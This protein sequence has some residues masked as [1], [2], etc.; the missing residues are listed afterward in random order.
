[1]GSPVYCEGASRSRSVSIPVSW[2]CLLPS[3]AIARPRLR[4]MELHSGSRFPLVITRS[5]NQP[6]GKLNLSRLVSLPIVQQQFSEVRRS[7]NDHRIA[8]PQRMIQYVE[9]FGSKFQ[10]DPFA[11]E[12]ALHQS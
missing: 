6:Q 9:R 5:K 12:S 11:N 8:S 10:M 7:G 4:G 3:A 1:M 2:I